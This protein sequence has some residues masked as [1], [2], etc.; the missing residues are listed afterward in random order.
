MTSK[1]IGI[2]FGVVAILVAV[3]FLPNQFTALTTITV[4][5]LTNLVGVAAIAG[6]APILILV[7]VLF[8]GGLVMFTGMTGA[9]GSGTKRIMSVIGSQI[10]LY[11]FLI[12][13]PTIITQFNTLWT[14]SPVTAQSFVGLCPLVILVGGLLGSGWWGVSAAGIKHAVKRYRGRRRARA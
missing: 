2:I 9:T 12:M 5:N 11:F 6:I 14:A 3:I 7:L 8:E 10:V 13:F 1:V 4:A